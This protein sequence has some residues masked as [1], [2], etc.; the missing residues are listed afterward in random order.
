[1]TTWEWRQSAETSLWSK[2]ASDQ[3]GVRSVQNAPSIDASPVKRPMRAR[4]RRFHLASARANRASSKFRHELTSEFQKDDCQF[5]RDSPKEFDFRP[6]GK[7]FQSE[8]G[9]FIANKNV[10]LG[11]A[12]QVANLRKS[13]AA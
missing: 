11:S 12:N 8:Y 2:K 7:V 1:M 10:K 6:P 13:L 9:V 4:T 5:S 3:W